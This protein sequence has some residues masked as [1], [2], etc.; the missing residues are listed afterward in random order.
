MAAAITSTVIGEY[1]RLSGAL[2]SYTLL[3]KASMQVRYG[4]RFAKKKTISCVDPTSP[5][6][7]RRCD[8][9]VCVEIKETP[10]LHAIHSFMRM[11]LVSREL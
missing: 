3:A 1:L 6:I 8:E 11:F 5:P 10:L 9:Y 4:E 7:F 2:L